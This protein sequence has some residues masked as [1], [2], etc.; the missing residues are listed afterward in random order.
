MCLHM[1]FH[2]THGV[3]IC[4]FHISNR[5][6]NEEYP[7]LFQN[8]RY[9]AYPLD[10]GSKKGGVSQSLASTKCK[11]VFGKWPKYKDVGTNVGQKGARNKH[12]LGRL[13]CAARC[14]AG[15]RTT[16]RTFSCG[17]VRLCDLAIG[18]CVCMCVFFISD[19]PSK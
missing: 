7:R 9:S 3:Y 14:H 16:G 2:M 6:R 11:Y 8:W 17:G 5:L 12:I 4:V 10:F 19:R 15:G 18:N 13:A 1:C